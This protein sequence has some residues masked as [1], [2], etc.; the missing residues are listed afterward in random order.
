[1]AK[2]VEHFRR[3]VMTRLIRAFYSDDF[4]GALGTIVFDMRPKGYSPPT[5]CCVYHDRAVIR[6][7]VIAALGFGDA[8]DDERTSTAEYAK[9]ALERSAVPSG[10]CLTVLGDACHGCEGNHVIVTEMC[11]NCVA[12]ACIEACR[13]GAISAGHGRSIIDKDKCKR[14]GMCVK[15]CPYDAIRK[16]IVPCELACPTRAITKQDDGRASIDFTRC[17]F[18]AHCLGAC[19]FGAINLR[20]QVVDVLS[21]IKARRTVIGLAAPSLFSQ[22][23]AKPGQLVAA[24]GKLGFSRVEEVARGADETALHEASEWAKRM[25]ANEPFMTTSCC[26]A[27]NE[28]RQKHAP[29]LAPFASKALTPMAYAALSARQAD[30]NAVVVFIGPCVAKYK[31]AFDTHEVDYIV[32]FEEIDCWLE[33]MGVDP[34]QLPDSAMPD[35]ISGEARGFG[36]TRG[37][38]KAVVSRGAAAAPVIIDG[39]DE[40]AMK[41]LKAMAKTRHCEGGNLVEVMACKGGCVGGGYVIRP[42]KAGQKH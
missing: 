2:A 33:A 11:H 3:E 30:P 36:E 29:E 42:H 20:S 32:T 25:A 14:C 16:E 24:L 27:F 8:D 39:L 28:W 38:S 21:A 10:E 4:P 7:R 15:A 31:E 18:C 34:A 5:R 9:K 37:V 1:M 13:L 26:A 17:I 12:K 22:F 19:P 6:S 35:D 23:S 41:S 40:E